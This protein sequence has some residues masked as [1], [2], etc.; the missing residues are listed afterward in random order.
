MN[1]IEFYKTPSG[2]VPFKKYI[3]K[4]KSQHK[5][6]E[7]TQIMAY[8]KK[9]EEYGLSINDK[10]KTNAIKFL[11]EQIYELRPDSSRIF[12]FHYQNGIF[13]ILHGY[14]KK[15]NKTDPKEIEKAIKEKKDYLTR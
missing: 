8:I 13:I 9:L 4:L 3:L 10:F 14:E 12:F 1:K 5:D 6:D 11:R 2:N 15:T 7:Y